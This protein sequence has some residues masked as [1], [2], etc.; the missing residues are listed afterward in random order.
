MVH[1][2]LGTLEQLQQQIASVATFRTVQNMSQ[3]VSK[4]RDTYQECVESVNERKHDLTELIKSWIAYDKILKLTNENIS[5]CLADLETLDLSISNLETA[6]DKL[7][8]FEI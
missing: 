2:L 4:V 7:K 8:V 6:E 1:P 5:R 3:S